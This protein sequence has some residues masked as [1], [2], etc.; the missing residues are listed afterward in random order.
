MKIKEEQRQKEIFSVDPESKEVQ[1]VDKH[2]KKIQ[3]EN[4]N[5]QLFFREH[6]ELINPDAKIIILEPNKCVIYKD[7]VSSGILNGGNHQLYS[8][9]EIKK[10]F[11]FFRK[12]KLKEPIMVD[13]VVYNPTLTYRSFWGTPNPI[14]YRDPETA[15]PVEFKGRGQYEI[16]IADVEKFHSTLV[17]SSK[18][19]SMVTLQERLKAFILQ[20][21]RHEFASVITNLHLGYIDIT[22]H[23]KEISETI[24]P[25]ISDKL[26]TEYGLCMPQLAIEEFT[27]DQG[28]RA[29][30]EEYLRNNRDEI[31]Y[32]KDAKELAAEIE[33]LDDKQW[34]RDKYLIG[35]K[36]EDYAKYLEVIKI[37]GQAKFSQPAPAN[38]HSRYCSGCGA[39]VEPDA[40]FC[41]K[42]GHQLKS[43][44]KV[45]RHCGKVVRSKGKFC[46][47][48]GKEL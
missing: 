12:R 25:I 33:R 36:R 44:D 13:V 34:E 14:P 11:L 8:D 2:A 41:P 46:P 16:R 38:N 15:I 37:L 48:C 6:F 17:G 42:C 40:T 26:V 24:L 32:K 35:L 45:C 28:K 31:K 30:I 43:N 47:H 39:E 18:D 1:K 7:G 4:S 29:E 23:E 3:I 10:G 19:F 9:E 22:S 5:E 21:I 27:I 20:E